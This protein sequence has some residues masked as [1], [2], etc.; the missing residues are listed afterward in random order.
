MS[1]T[2]ITERLDAL[3]AAVSTM[4]RMVGARLTRAE[5][6]ERLRV[7]RNTLNT[8]MDAKGFPRPGVDG[9]W[10]LAEIIEWESQK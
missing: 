8:Y 3:T 2:E 7:S 4:A 6:L 10:L 1:S 9:K 5:V